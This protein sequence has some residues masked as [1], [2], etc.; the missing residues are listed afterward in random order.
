MAQGKK[1]AVKPEKWIISIPSNA[2]YCSEKIRVGQFA[3]SK[4]ALTDA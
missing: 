3:Y 2:N 4:S 1:K